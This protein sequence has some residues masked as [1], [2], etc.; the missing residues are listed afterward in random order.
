MFVC[1]SKNQT[2]GKM[3][4]Y[5]DFCKSMEKELKECLMAD[6]QVKEQKSIVSN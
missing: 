2:E 1:Y 3:A 5:K 6:L 4:P